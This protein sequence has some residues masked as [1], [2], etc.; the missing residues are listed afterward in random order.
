MAGMISRRRGRR[1]SAD[2]REGEKKTVE[3]DEVGKEEGDDDDDD[4]DDGGEREEGS[5]FAT[6]SK[7]SQSA[8]S[9]PD[10]EKSTEAIMMA[11]SGIRFAR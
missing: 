6:C 2:E 8:R 11:S 1:G 7:T 4:D 5:P 9:P 3:E 10:L